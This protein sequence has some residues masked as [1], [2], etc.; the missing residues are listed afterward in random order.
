MFFCL[1]FISYL[2][3]TIDY[4]A[5]AYKQYGVVAV[6]NVLAPMI[7]WVMV[8]KIGDDKDK[9]Y[10]GMVAVALGG[11]TSALLGIWLTKTWG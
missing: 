4:R 8:K 10:W 2:N 5:V 11:V 7:A 3:I 9:G 6:C 1:Q